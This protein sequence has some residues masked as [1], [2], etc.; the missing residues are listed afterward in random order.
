MTLLVK[1]FQVSRSY[2]P[3]PSQKARVKFRFNPSVS[4]SQTQNLT[5]LIRIASQM[6][7]FCSQE[8]FIKVH[9][10]ASDH[11]AHLVVKWKIVSTSCA[12]TEDL[13]TAVV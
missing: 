13:S 4:F 3:I 6:P 10:A 2:L 7:F 9:T 12:L 8:P 1:V 11:L 5:Q